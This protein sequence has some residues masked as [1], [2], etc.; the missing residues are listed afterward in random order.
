MV[1]DVIEIANSRSA[2]AAIDQFE[3][4]LN[5][6]FDYQGSLS[7]YNKKRIAFKNAAE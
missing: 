2:Y 6:T 5:K 4:I 3:T 1:D 7:Y